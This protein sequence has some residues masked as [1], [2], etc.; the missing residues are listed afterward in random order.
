MASMRSSRLW[1]PTVL[2]TCS[3]VL[4]ALAHPSVSAG[5]PAPSSCLGQP[6]TIVGTHGDDVL[7]GT[8]HRD[9]V[10]AGPG[11]DV[12]RGL[13][14]T[15]YICGGRGGDRLFAGP[16]L[17]DFVD[18][19]R[20]A[21]SLS[22]GAGDDFMW[23]GD[24]DDFLRSGSGRNLMWGDS[25]TAVAQVCG[26]TDL[27]GGAGSAP[28]D[29]RLSGQ[30]DATCNRFMSGPGADNINAPES[31]LVFA[32][33]GSGNDHIS[34]G[35]AQFQNLNGEEGNDSIE[36][37]GTRYFINLDGGAG[38]DVVKGGDRGRALG[39]LIGGDGADVVRG[40][41]GPNWVVGGTGNDLVTGGPGA[42][43]V[44]GDDIGMDIG[45]ADTVKGGT[46]SDVVLPG[47]GSD[48]LTGGP[49]FDWLD[50]QDQSTGVSV[51][52]PSGT[53]TSP[54]ER[55]EF[56]EFEAVRGTSGQDVLMGDEDINLFAGQGGDDWID[57]RGDFDMA[58]Y[59][60]AGGPVRVDLGEGTATGSASDTLSSIEGAMGSRFDDSLLGGEESNLLI[61]QGGSDELFGLG[62]N[63]AFFPE[64][65][66]E[67][68]KDCEE[69]LGGGKECSY[70]QFGEPGNDVIV[71][72]EGS[73]DLIDYSFA[74]NDVKVDLVLGSATGQEGPEPYHP[75]QGTDAISEV[76]WIAGSR[77]DDELA[78]SLV[79]NAIFAGAG[80]DAL[81][82]RQGNDVLSASA[83]ADQ[84]DGG[85]GVDSCIGESGHRLNC[86]LSDRPP[87]HPLYEVRTEWLRWSRR[88][89]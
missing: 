1:R 7:I 84:L 2:V 86:E 48:R 42:D 79:E 23:G 28:G 76:E 59:D 34:A 45:G 58:F 50:Y 89:K 63:D 37:L 20:G 13:E 56:E 55:D 85:E 77:Y 68:N 47:G 26:E 24:G 82:G 8:P 21:D 70:V 65:G 3:M 54:G 15:D 75:G 72:G 12:V 43:Q 9:V 57:G 5:P 36:T 64:G 18:G 53:V 14:G 19:G 38:R 80:D 46:G 40:G 31:G 60:S 52:L 41:G 27:S 30:P 32:W 10:S 62:G 67:P 44:M 35:L 78:G 69:M 39:N 4:A 87:L 17:D 22:G 73:R 25:G 49:G 29:D 51:T 11:R 74:F 83:G 66:G 88:Y 71:G 33:S 6:A 16:G 81:E 61:G